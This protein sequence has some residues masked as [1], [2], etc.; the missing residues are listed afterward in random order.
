MRDANQITDLLFTID[1]VE[2]A[3]GRVFLT[4]FNQLYVELK[5]PKTKCSTNFPLGNI[6]I[7]ADKTSV[8]IDVKPN[9]TASRD[10]IHKSVLKDLNRS[11]NS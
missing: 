9:S 4:P 10:L 8:K 6:E 11:A 1:D 3:V 7:F 2:Y 5:N